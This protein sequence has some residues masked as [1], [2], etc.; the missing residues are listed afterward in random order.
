M[1]S[2]TRKTTF[3][4]C[5]LLLCGFVLYS[6]S[7]AMQDSEKWE[8]PA[9]AKKMKNPTTTDNE[10]L[11]I[12]KTIYAKHCKSCHGKTGEGDGTKAEELD[13]PTG[14]FTTEEFQSQTDGEL[15]YKTKTGRDDMPEFKKKIPDDEDIWLLVNYMRT[16]SE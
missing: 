4:V 6:F 5:A 14:D 12:G 16:L 7:A 9:A 8:V 3:K 1:K 10:N 2:I 13:T 11:A 15:F